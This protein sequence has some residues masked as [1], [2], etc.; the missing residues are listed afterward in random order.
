MPR[1]SHPAHPP[2][3]VRTSRQTDRHTNRRGAQ[4]QPLH[5]HVAAHPAPTNTQDKE[6]DIPFRGAFTAFPPLIRIFLARR[7]RDFVA[8]KPGHE[9]NVIFSRHEK[10]SPPVSNSSPS[11]ATDRQCMTRTLDPCE[12][13][14]ARRVIQSADIMRCAR[15]GPSYLEPKG[16]PFAELKELS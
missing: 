11:P 8:S 4:D 9:D 5:G 13:F 7:S 12:V 16:L 15:S 1:N 3:Q 10:Q 14:D 2:N 6:I